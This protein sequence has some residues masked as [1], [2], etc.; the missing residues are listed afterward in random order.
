[1]SATLTLPA[2]TP[3]SYLPEEKRAAL[4]R[5]GGT[6]L[7]YIAESQ[8]AGKVNDMDAAWAW[9]ALAELPAHSL[10]RLKN[11]EGANFIRNLGFNTTKADATYGPG[12]LDRD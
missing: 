9:M 2:K 5:E 7:V 11:S 3:K 4:L 6:N 12:W 8:E 10:M 1:M